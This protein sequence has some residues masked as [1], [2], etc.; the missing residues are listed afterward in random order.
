MQT[1]SRVALSRADHANFASFRA[2]LHATCISADARFRRGR[3]CNLKKKK[4]KK[5]T[6]KILQSLLYRER[7]IYGYCVYFSTIVYKQ[8]IFPLIPPQNLSQQSFN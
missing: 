5:M 4:K 7:E 3:I 1:C 2:R 6:K 8:I